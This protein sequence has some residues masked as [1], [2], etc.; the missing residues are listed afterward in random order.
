[1]E[2]PGLRYRGEN[3]WRSAQKKKKKGPVSGRKKYVH[4]SRKKKR[5]ETSVR[6]ERP[7]DG[8]SGRSSEGGKGDQSVQ[9]F[10][11]GR[12]GGG[13]KVGVL[14]GKKSTLR[15]VFRM[16]TRGGLLGAWN[17][18]SRKFRGLIVRKQSYTHI[19]GIIWENIQKRS[20]V[21]YERGRN[22][23]SCIKL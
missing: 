22:L 15:E 3:A 18:W 6:R 14:F 20:T 13:V 12:H 17:S 4:R 9:S 16:D 23:F 11:R 2:G 5:K 10:Y 7:I 21:V 19:C 1:V 8:L